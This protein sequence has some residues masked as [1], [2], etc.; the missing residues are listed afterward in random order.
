VVGGLPKD[1][2]AGEV[3]ISKREEVRVSHL[4][5]QGA[6]ISWRFILIAVAITIL[7]FVL[8]QLRLVVIP[9]I[10]ALLVSTLLVPPAAWLRSKGWPALLATWAVILTCFLVFAGVGFLLVPQIALE[11]D[12][13]GSTLEQGSEDVLTWLAEGPLDV[14]RQEVDGYVQQAFD[15]LRENSSSISSGVLTGA[16]R[17]GE[18]VAATLLTFVL[19]FFFVKDGDKMWSWIVERSAP[20]RKADLGEIGRRAWTA[21]SAYVRGT[22]IIALADAILIGAALLILGVPL[23]APLIILTF[24]GGFFPLVGATIAGLVAALIALVGGGVIDALI[25]GGWVIVVQQVEG[26]VL[27]PVVM[28][29]AVK[30][31][32]VVILLALT[33]GALVAGVAGAFLAVPATAVA[34]AVGSYVRSQRSPAELSTPA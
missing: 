12:E 6:A 29:R 32:P 8:V 30:L 15:R 25:V 21:M 26:D 27:Q 5:A 17:V 13:L 3:R 10:V 34:T 28:G 16:I 4:L 33:A 20:D 19:V 14:S 11:M 31:H 2:S 7:G 24:L 18:I 22:A 23:A 9:V 1:G